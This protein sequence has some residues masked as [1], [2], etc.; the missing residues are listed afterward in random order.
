MRSELPEDLS[1]IIRHLEAAYPQE[2]CGVILRA[3]PE[4][5]WRIRPLLNAYDRYHAADPVRFPHTSRTAYLFEP[6]EWLALNEEADARGERIAC[7]FHS[8]VNGSADFSSEDRAQASPAGQPLL[9]GV[10]Y[11]VVA[12]EQGRA[13]VARL[14][15]WRDGDFR[16]HLVPLGVE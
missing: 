16:D 1:D 4:G 13:T 7:V 11:L 9:P 12:V 15:R 8:H 2:G 10:S 3:E 14:F 6:R 5:P